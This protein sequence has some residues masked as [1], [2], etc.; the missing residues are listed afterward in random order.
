MNR[1]LNDVISGSGDLNV[2]IKEKYN[3]ITDKTLEPQ[4]RREIN[5]GA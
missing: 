2:H 5:T 1:F 3:S 4:A